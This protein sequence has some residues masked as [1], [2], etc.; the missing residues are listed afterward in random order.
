MAAVKEITALKVKNCI[1]ILLSFDL[2]LDA[3]P[4]FRLAA[5]Y[6]IVASHPA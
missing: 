1:S 5:A 2:G 3:L 6:P 4:M